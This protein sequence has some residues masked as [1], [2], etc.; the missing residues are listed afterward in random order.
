MFHRKKKMQGI[1]YTT[2]TNKLWIVQTHCN[3]RNCEITKLRN[4]TMAQFRKLHKALGLLQF[5]KYAFFS[6]LSANFFLFQALGRQAAPF[7]AKIRFQ[8]EYKICY[9]YIS[10]ITIRLGLIV[11]CKIDFFLRIFSR[12]LLISSTRARRSTF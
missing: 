1:F 7:K 3:L 11:I 10:Q 6:V 8:I 12:F 2:S 5:A 4:S 9:R